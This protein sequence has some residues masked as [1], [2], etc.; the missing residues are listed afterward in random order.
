MA[1]RMQAGASRTARPV[2]MNL[3]ESKYTVT[4]TCPASQ[5]LLKVP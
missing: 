3:S 1:A 2:T 5:I 4:R